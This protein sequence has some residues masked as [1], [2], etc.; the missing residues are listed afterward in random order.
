MFWTQLSIQEPRQN[1]DNLSIYDLVFPSLWTGLFHQPDW[2]LGH[3][4]CD[5]DVCV[6]VCS[7]HGGIWLV[8]LW[9]ERCSG[10]KDMRL[11]GGIDTT[12]ATHSLAKLDNIS[13]VE[14]PVSTLT[15]TSVRWNV[16]D[17]CFYLGIDRGVWT[18]FIL[19]KHLIL[20]AK[21]I[22]K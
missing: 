18:M 14:I 7:E 19:M 21:H 10:H 1:D 9:W 8:C 3:C 22:I 17:W 6:Y 15:R 20:L 16:S 11:D 5:V 4:L 13:L 2:S 12:F